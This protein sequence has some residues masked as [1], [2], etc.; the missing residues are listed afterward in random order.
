MRRLSSPLSGLPVRVGVTGIVASLIAWSTVARVTRLDDW[1]RDRSM[2]EAMAAARAVP[3][4]C[5]LAVRTVWVYRSA[6]YSYWHRDVPIYFETWAQAQ[7]LPGSEFPLR[8]ESVLNGK[9]VPQYPD[10]SLAAHTDKFNVIVGAHT[11][12]LPGFKEQSCFGAGT[13]D[14]RRFCVFARPGDCG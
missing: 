9:P 13:I 8:L 4:V 10:A 5:G 6:G 7:K 14:D 1:H 3:G 2:L 12:Q 11:D